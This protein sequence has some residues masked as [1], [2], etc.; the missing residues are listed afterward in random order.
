MNPEYRAV[1]RD[2]AKLWVDAGGTP[3]NIK[4]VLLELQQHISE[5]QHYAKTVK[6]E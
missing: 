1:L 5:E 3:K 4:D 2:M 6:K